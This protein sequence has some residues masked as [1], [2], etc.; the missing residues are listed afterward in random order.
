MSDL[1]PVLSAMLDEDEVL[2]H[3]IV[4]LDVMMANGDRDL[5]V[6]TKSVALWEARG[7]LREAEGLLGGVDDE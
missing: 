6:R 7:M 1:Y 5:R 3:G 2:I 4:V